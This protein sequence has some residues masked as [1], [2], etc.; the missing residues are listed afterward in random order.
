MN[1]FG[2]LG[3]RGFSSHRNRANRLLETGRRRAVGIAV[4][5]VLLLIAVA[6]LLVALSRATLTFALPPPEGSNVAQHGSTRWTPGVAATGVSLVAAL[7]ALGWLLWLAIGRPS[8]RWWW[9]VSALVLL[10]GVITA[11]ISGLDT[12]SF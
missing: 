5:A 12:G 9:P 11:V 2:K 3:A 8:P 1:K 7:A 10:A 4:A 6:V